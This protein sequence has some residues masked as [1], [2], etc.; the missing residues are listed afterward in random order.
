MVLHK[1]CDNAKSFLSQNSNE[2][3]GSTTRVMLF[4]L[5]LA[6]WKKR[7][8]DAGPLVTDVF[9]IQIRADESLDDP[10]ASPTI[11]S[12]CWSIPCITSHPGGFTLAEFHIRIDV[13]SC[14]GQEGSLKRREHCCDSFCGC[15]TVCIVEDCKTKFRHPCKFDWT[16]FQGGMEAEE[17]NNDIIP[18]PCSLHSVLVN[19]VDHAR[20]VLPQT[21]RG[22][23]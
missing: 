1:Q 23:P 9:P 15:D 5:A 19:S 21:L 17:N 11:F 6:H 8:H 22:L 18:S 12:L 16:T 13:S 10:T 4:A 3:T 20:V 2:D 14:L 7:N